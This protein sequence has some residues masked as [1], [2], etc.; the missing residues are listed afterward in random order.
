MELS[1]NIPT[2]VFATSSFAQDETPPSSDL[3]DADSMSGSDSESDSESS[4]SIIKKKSMPF[5]STEKP[6]TFEIEGRCSRNI[7]IRICGTRMAGGVSKPFPEGFEEF[8]QGTI[9][10]H[11]TK[12]SEVGHILN[13]CLSY[14]LLKISFLKCRS[15][16]VSIFQLFLFTRPEA[17][18]MPTFRSIIAL[19]FRQATALVRLLSNSLLV[20]KAK[21]HLL[22]VR[23]QLCFC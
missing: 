14:P 9:V 13:C 20:E 6:Y 23:F 19:C 3:S 22:D 18:K 10:I 11:E 15:T 2:K 16:S 4:M 17:L 1:G 21:E 8:V 12:N 5:F 7:H